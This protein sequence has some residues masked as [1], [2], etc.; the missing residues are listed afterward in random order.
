[1]GRAIRIGT[2]GSH[3]ARW[4]SSWVADQL[5]QH[6][7]GLEVVLI[8]IK[9]QGDRDRNSPLAAIG[10]TGLFT[11]EI[12]RALIDGE[13]EVAVHSLKD[14][15]TR[16]PEGLVLGAVPPREAWGD[17]LIA[18]AHKTLEALP[19]GARVGTSSLRR[20]AMLLH[21]RPDLQ[22]VSIRGNV[23][24]RLK[25]ALNGRLD[26]VVLAEAGLR[27]LDL[28]RHVTQRLGPPEFLPAVGQGALGIECRADDAATRALLAPLDDPATHR[29]VRAERRLLAELEGG[30]II[31][32][33]AWAREVAEGLAL[34]AAVFDID[35]RERLAAS[36]MGPRDDPDALG[37]AVA[38][39]LRQRG[40]E[41]L[42]RPA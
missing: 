18:P 13:V 37:R 21:A 11:K 35:G 32:L 25:Q 10:G 30:C 22:V 5:Q 2:R 1:M 23:E 4:Q 20:R 6:H 14:L 29:A 28:E 3:L 40:A 34:D 42:L 41:R 16:G 17:A 7:P 8:E 27:R 24:T 12:Q 19:P 36:L 31:P 15:P 9:T 26:G 33:G 38:Q 39:D